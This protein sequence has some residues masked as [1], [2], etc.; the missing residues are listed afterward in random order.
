M[1]DG[2]ITMGI[3]IWLLFT[4]LYFLLELNVSPVK[5]KN[6]SFWAIFLNYQ[7]AKQP[8]MTDAELNSLLH[9]LRNDENRSICMIALF[10]LS[11][12]CRLKEILSTKWRDVNIEKASSLS[13]PAVANDFDQSHWIPVH[14]RYCIN[15][16][17][18]LFLNQQTGKP[19]TPISKV[20]V[21]LRKKVVLVSELP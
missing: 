19:Y 20:W 15:W 8:W 10:L 7:N 21:R 4:H 14:L 6:S 1:I 5:L 13:G 9:V 11:T 17:G 16:V 12:G 3:L 18:V 2:M